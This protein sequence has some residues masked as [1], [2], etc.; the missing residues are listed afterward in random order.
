MTEPTIEAHTQSR[1]CVWMRVSA[2][3]R[4]TNQLRYWTYSPLRSLRT[5]TTVSHSYLSKVSVVCAGAQLLRDERE[6]V[7]ATRTTPDDRTSA[8]ASGPIQSIFYPFP[9]LDSELS[10]PH[11]HPQASWGILEECGGGGVDG[12]RGGGVDGGAVA[13]IVDRTAMLVEWPIYGDRA[14]VVPNTPTFFG[15]MHILF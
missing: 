3:G 9:W 7:G 4:K 2:L 11:L 10:S 1:C 5:V 6:P 14:S 12:G 13:F 8:L 15:T